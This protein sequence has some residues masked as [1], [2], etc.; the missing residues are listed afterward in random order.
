[1]TTS[2]DRAR[3][4]FERLASTPHRRSLAADRIFRQLRKEAEAKDAR[5]REPEGEAPAAG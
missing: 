2:Q 3:A 4:L 5:E 1:M